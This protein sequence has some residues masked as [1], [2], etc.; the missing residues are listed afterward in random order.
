MTTKTL[1][2]N[3][4]LKNLE[5]LVG[6]WKLGGD[7]TG[8]VI[9]EWMEGGFFLVQHIDLHVFGNHVKGIEIIGH[10]QP[11]GEEPGKEIRSR[12]YDNAGNTFDYVYELK[13]NTLTIWGG[14]KGSP[15][16]F[17]GTFGEDGKTS[18]GEWVYPGGGYKST[19]TKIK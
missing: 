6:T 2:P 14:E 15:S 3:P 17:K 19:M 18:T 9:Y 7:T 11:F 10:W 1:T 16:Y 13:G 5:K 8:T 4:D 12:A